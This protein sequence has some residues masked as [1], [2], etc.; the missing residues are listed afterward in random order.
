MAPEL[1]V[2][3]KPPDPTLQYP[4]PNYD[5]NNDG[6]V[7]VNDANIIHSLIYGSCSPQP[8]SIGLHL[9]STYARSKELYPAPTATDACASSGPASCGDI[10]NSCAWCSQ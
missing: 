7:D 8:C 5:V 4:N 1:R 9:C 2:V 3:C 10:N 6:V